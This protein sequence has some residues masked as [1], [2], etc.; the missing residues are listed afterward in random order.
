LPTKLKKILPGERRLSF[1]RP[2]LYRNFMPWTDAALPEPQGRFSPS[3]LLSPLPIY[4]ILYEE[5]SNVI[6]MAEPG[7]G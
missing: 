3:K 2:S 1:D 6:F 4:D 5:F 7:R